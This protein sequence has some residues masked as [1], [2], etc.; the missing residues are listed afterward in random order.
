MLLSVTKCCAD[1]ALWY[2]HEL[3]LSKIKIAGASGNAAYGYSS[4]PV[5][6]ESAG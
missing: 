1:P 5:C 2:G 6:F 4:W 3:D